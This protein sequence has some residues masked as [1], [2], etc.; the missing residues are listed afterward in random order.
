MNKRQ[1]CSIIKFLYKNAIR[2]CLWYE[3]KNSGK[4]EFA[5]DGK[6]RIK[7]FDSVS[8]LTRYCATNNFSCSE[9]SLTIYDLNVL[10]TLLKEANHLSNY[11]L[12]IDIWNISGDIAFT[13]HDNFLGDNNNFLDVYN[14]LFYA[15]NLPEINSS[16]KK[17]V[18]LWSKEEEKKL[19]KVFSSA[20]ELIHK[21]IFG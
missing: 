16:P 11:D 9:S 17:Y 7:T 5:V 2:Y 1:D 14:K 19:E 3:N 15:L 8:E 10:Q 18:P 6:H 12:L 13:V 4:D 20:I 21:N